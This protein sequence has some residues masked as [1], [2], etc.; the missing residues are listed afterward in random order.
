[1]SFL[2][3]CLVVV[4]SLLPALVPE[5]QLPPEPLYQHPRTSDDNHEPTSY[6]A[7]PCLPA[8]PG[9]V[10]SQTTATPLHVTK[11]PTSCLAAPPIHRLV[12]DVTATT[13]TP[14]EDRTSFPA[15]RT[16]STLRALAPGKLI[17]IPRLRLMSLVLVSVVRVRRCLRSDFVLQAY[18]LM[19][20]PIA[21]E[22]RPPPTNLV[23]KPLI[24][25][26]LSRPLVRLSGAQNICWKNCWL[27]CERPSSPR[28]ISQKCSPSC[29][30]SL[31]YNQW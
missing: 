14:R 13:A 2:A 4:R 17:Q 18:R 16:S 6:R 1:M 21:L 11:T 29:V 22:T 15:L 25:T 24:S 30:R 9:N 23:T 28:R 31:S 10:P 3:P 19:T 5:P 8:A 27:P 20:T 12:V 7:F 26:F